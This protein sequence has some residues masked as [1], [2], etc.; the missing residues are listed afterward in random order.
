MNLV[1]EYVKIISEYTDT[2]SVYKIASGYHIISHLFGRYFEMKNVKC[3]KPNVWFLPASIPGRMRRSTIQKYDEITISKTL[4]EF[5]KKSGLNKK[6]AYKK[7]AMSIIEDGSP[8]GLCDAIIGGIKEQK[9]WHYDICSGEFGDVLRKISSKGGYSAGVD[10]LLSR[11]YYGERYIERLSQRNSKKG[12]SSTRFIPPNV[13]VTMFS[14]IQEPKFYL[15]ETMSRQG[16]LRRIKLIYVKNTDLTMDNWSSPF[17]N[18][19]DNYKNDLEQFAINELLPKMIKFDKFF[20]M[21]QFKPLTVDLETS[22]RTTIEKIARRADKALILDDCDFNIHNQTTWEHLVKTTILEA[23][24]NGDVHETKDFMACIGDENAY[25]RAKEFIDTVDKHTEGI[26]DELTTVE[27]KSKREKDLEKV[28]RNINRAGVDG[29][30][31]KDLLN[32]LW[33]MTSD[34]LTPLLQTLDQ[35][36]R[37][38]FTKT[39]RDGPGVK[40]ERYFSKIYSEKPLTN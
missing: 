10:T 12:V 25:K 11:L 36:G 6:D 33:G 32:S 19:Y 28:L 22:V 2:P 37:I 7:W 16:L 3:G 40:G 39:N 23:L 1:N 26:M 20:T 8:Q 27:I 21:N 4:I 18:D 30:S 24:A 13:Y 31:R 17:K 14:C 29:I 35:A 38:Y 5:Y 34:K 9:L 15:N